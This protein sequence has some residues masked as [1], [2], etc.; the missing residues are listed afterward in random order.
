MLEL[1]QSELILDFVHLAEWLSHHV[2]LAERITHRI[3]TPVNLRVR[4]SYRTLRLQLL[5]DS[6]NR[7]VD[8][9]LVPFRYDSMHSAGNSIWKTA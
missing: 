1:S 8:I 7:V 5:R 2:R 9:F 4:L 6:S 3:A